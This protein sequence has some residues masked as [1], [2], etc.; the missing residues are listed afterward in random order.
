MYANT[1]EIMLN[2]I[3]KFKTEVKDKTFPSK[4]NV[5]EKGGK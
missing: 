4:E 3:E 1:F 5:F 2:A